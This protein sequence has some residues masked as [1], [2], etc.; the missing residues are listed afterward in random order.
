MGWVTCFL[1]IHFARFLAAQNF[2]L[3]SKLPL[4][5]ATVSFTVQSLFS[6]AVFGLKILNNL[7]IIYLFS[8]HLKF[9]IL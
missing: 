2:P 9:N 3:Y 5:L 8:K 6:L 7:T 4:T 1:Y